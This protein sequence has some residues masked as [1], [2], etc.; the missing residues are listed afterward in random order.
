MAEPSLGNARVL[1]SGSRSLTPVVTMS[2]FTFSAD[3]AGLFAPTPSFPFDTTAGAGV[4]AAADAALGAG[5]AATTALAR[6]VMRA[7]TT[8]RPASGAALQPTS[9]TTLVNVQNRIDVPNRII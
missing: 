3:A 6:S 1:A 7:T 2:R 9:T 4:P 5:A 8:P